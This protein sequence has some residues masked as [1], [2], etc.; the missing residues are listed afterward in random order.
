MTW[1]LAPSAGRPKVAILVSQYDHC[2]ADLL[3]RHHS[4]ELACDISLIISNHEIGQALAAFYGI[5][6]HHMPM[7]KEN[8]QHVEQQQIAL[9]KAN[10]V[11]LVVLARYMQILSS[12]FVSNYPQQIINVHHSFLPAFSGAR[13]Y[14]RAFER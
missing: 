14:Q 9:L 2:L 4:G 10:N 11:D 8:K 13:P 6:F 7:T 3:Y 12:E 1:R 5:P